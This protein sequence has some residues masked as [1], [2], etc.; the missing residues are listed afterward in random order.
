MSTAFHQQ[1]DGLSEIPTKQ[2]TRY[3]QT[4]ATYHQNKWDTSLPRAEYAYHVTRYLS[5]DQSLFKLDLENSPSIQYAFVVGQWL[6]DEMGSRE[7]RALIESF[8]VSWLDALDPLYDIPDSQRA[9]VYKSQS[10]YTLAVGDFLLLSSTVLLFTY[11]KQNP[12]P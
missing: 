5:T 2:V 8:Q 9:G 11:T 12:S 1:I 3:L 10:P 4:F 7:S 6:D